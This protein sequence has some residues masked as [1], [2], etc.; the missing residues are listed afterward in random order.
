MTTFT[1]FNLYIPTECLVTKVDINPLGASYI[2]FTY[3]QREARF[4]F[5]APLKRR[6]R[7]IPITEIEGKKVWFHH[8]YKKGLL[9]AWIIDEK[10][11]PV[12]IVPL[13]ELD[14]VANKAFHENYE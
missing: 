4:K 3:E 6:G 9:V 14:D 12:R 7:K 10:G 11:A 2:Y 5:P 8:N 1:Q 13:V